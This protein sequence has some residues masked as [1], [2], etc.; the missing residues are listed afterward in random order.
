MPEDEIQRIC[1]RAGLSEH[2]AALHPL[3]FVDRLGEVHLPLDGYRPRS[4]RR[5]GG[6][7]LR[8]DHPFG[9]ASVEVV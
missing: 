1:D 3:G 4:A 6:P 9:V 8:R 5:N 7:S 2:P